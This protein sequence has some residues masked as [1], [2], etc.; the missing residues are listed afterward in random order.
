MV[1][2]FSECTLMI[3][4]Y[5]LRVIPIVGSKVS[6]WGPVEFI[7]MFVCLYIS[8]SGCPH[9]FLVIICATHNCEQRMRP[10]ATGSNP[11][12]GIIMSFLVC[13]R[14]CQSVR[15]FVYPSVR[16]SDRASVSVSVCAS[17][18]SSAGLLQFLYLY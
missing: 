7:P 12:S 17:I 4:L 1:L 16:L 18:R 15:P 8:L 11:L 10:Q 13:M 9:R 6:Q 5:L 2:N 14:I 3:Y